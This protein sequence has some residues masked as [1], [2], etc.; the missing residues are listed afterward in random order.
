MGA[1]ETSMRIGLAVVSLMLGA[2]IGASLADLRTQRANCSR[3]LAAARHG[4]GRK[5]TSRCSVRVQGNTACHHF[6]VLFL[7]AGSKALVT[8]RRARQASLNARCISKE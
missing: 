6:H 3:M 8:G 4:V 1:L 7:E 2:L 5:A